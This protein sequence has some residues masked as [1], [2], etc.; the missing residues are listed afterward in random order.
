MSSK[1]LRIVTFNYLPGGYH[2]SSE[3]IH[4]HGHEHVL[5]ITTP[6]PLSRLTPSYIEVVKK[7]PRA[8]EFLITTR[9]NTVAAPVIRALK[10][11]LILSFTFPYRITP[12]ICEIPRFGAI[13]IHPSVLPAYRGPNPMR[14]FYEGA[15]RFGATAHWI[16]PEY[17]TGNILSLK[18]D[19]LP[20]EVTPSII[21]QWGEMIRNAIADGTARAMDGDQGTPQD[22]TQATY[23]APYTEQEKWIDFNNPV[24]V[25]QRQVLA[26]DISG[27]LARAQIDGIP[28][29][30]TTVE[31]VAGYQQKTGHVLEK[32]SQYAVV[33]V[34][35]GVLRLKIQPIQASNAPSYPLQIE[36]FAA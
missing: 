13:N 6:G 5:S 26:L 16:A 7:A 33:A 1:P 3:W 20:D 2:F 19:Q 11:D 25:I 35:D 29:K 21:P 17:D 23:A 34:A 24:H 12:E 10:P 8:Q 15:P 18:S 27:G 30:V 14:Q 9:M 31:K 4:N 22:D 36:Q 28:F 32:S